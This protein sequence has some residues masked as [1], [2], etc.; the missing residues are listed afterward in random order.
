MP[1]RSLV[2]TAGLFVGVGALTLLL[3]INQAFHGQLVGTLLGEAISFRV[4]GLDFVVVGLIIALAALSLA[5]VLSLNLGERAAEFITLRTVGWSDRQ[6][7]GVMAGEARV[8]GGLGSVPG[9]LLGL[10][11]G[12]QLGA[13]IIPPRS[14]RGGGHPRRR[15]R[16]AARLAACAPAPSRAHSPHRPGRG[17]GRAARSGGGVEPADPLQHLLY[18]DGLRHLELVDDPAVLEPDDALAGACHHRVVGGDDQGHP[19]PLA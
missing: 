19:S 14:G 12:A 6:L 11:V 4:R 15:P 2:G 17:I 1:A 8:L 13:G 16:L 9:A 3:A 10:L 7:G 5:D 18:G